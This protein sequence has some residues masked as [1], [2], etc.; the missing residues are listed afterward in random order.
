MKRRCDE[1]N[2][3]NNKHDNEQYYVIIIKIKYEDERAKTR[4]QKIKDN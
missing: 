3:D 1:M 2:C 4:Q